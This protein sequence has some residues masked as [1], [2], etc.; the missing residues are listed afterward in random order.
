[1]VNAR[2]LHSFLSLLFITQLPA[3]KATQM[4][5]IIW[6]G[7][8]DHGRGAGIQELAKVIESIIP[9][10]KV[11]CI[12]T[13]QSDIQDIEDSYLKPSAQQIDEVCAQLMSDPDFADG[14]HMIGLSQGGLFVRALA[15]KCPFKTLGSIISIG[16]PQMG[17]FGVPKCRDVGL[18]PYCSL[19]EKLL[20]YGAYTDFVQNHLVQAQYWHDPLNE[21]KF[22]EKCHFLTDINQET[23]INQTY[24]NNILKAKAIVLVKFMDDTVLK[25][26]QSEWFGFYVPMTTEKFQT[27]RETKLYRED[28]LGL[29]Q[30]DETNRL[31]FLQVDGDHLHFSLEWFENEIVR[32]F[33]T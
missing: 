21:E 17:V 8:G 5:V 13:G 14:T 15:Q 12:T 18:L 33:L 2:I 27:L 20:S 7:M 10:I 23:R 30:L 19:M 6:H 31:H 11:K 28:R 32:Q 26:S 9:G 22:R 16:G 1:M 3:L 29:K 4:A 24:K 25:P